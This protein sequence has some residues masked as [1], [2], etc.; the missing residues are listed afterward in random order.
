MARPKSFK[1]I[2][3]DALDQHASVWVWR[4]LI[5]LGIC[6]GG[7]SSTSR[8]EEPFRGYVSWGFLGV[9]GIG[10]VMLLVGLCIKPPPKT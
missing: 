10:I 2:C 6:I 8:I 7:L 4:S 9:G 5:A 1:R 3:M